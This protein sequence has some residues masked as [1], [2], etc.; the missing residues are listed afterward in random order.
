M[1]NKIVTGLLIALITTTAVAA[2]K[3]YKLRG[4]PV[5]GSK[6][7]TVDAVS[8]IPFDKNYGQ[9]TAQQKKIFRSNYDRLTTSEKP[10]FPVG[11]TQSIYKPIIKGHKE[12]ARAGILFLVATVGE[13]G[14]VENVQ[15][16]NSPAESM[17]EYATNVLFNTAFDP[18][19]CEGQPCKM[20]FPFE[21]DL[22]TVIKASRN[23]KSSIIGN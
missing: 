20:E 1:F 7:K 2:T 6:F 23:S 5:A 3:K 17:T 21:F 22:P 15:V 18:A 11:G 16:Y 4:D 9:L 10:P 12:I 14:K 19:T 8:L 13:T